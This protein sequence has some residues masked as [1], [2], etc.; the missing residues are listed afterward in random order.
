M[1]QHANE[2]SAGGL[3]DPSYGPAMGIYVLTE[4]LVFRLLVH[5]AVVRKWHPRNFIVTGSEVLQ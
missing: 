2:Y 3:V 1:A 4:S 5:G